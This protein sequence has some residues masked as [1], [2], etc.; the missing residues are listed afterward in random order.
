[1]SL[2][3]FLKPL[4][5]S[6]PAPFFYYFSSKDVSNILKAN[7]DQTSAGKKTGTNNTNSLRKYSPY[8]YI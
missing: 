3:V 2:R 8:K 5:K 7:T 1:M 6:E 4:L